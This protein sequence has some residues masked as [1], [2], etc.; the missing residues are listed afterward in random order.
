[1]NKS[2]ASQKPVSSASNTSTP[3]SELRQFGELLDRFF[4]NVRI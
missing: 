2:S 1:M 3:E 4:G